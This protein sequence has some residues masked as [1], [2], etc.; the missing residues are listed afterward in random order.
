MEVQRSHDETGLTQRV[1]VVQHLQRPHAG[2][3]RRGEWRA[4]VGDLSGS[5]HQDVV[6]G[7]D[8]VGGVDPHHSGRQVAL[9]SAPALHGHWLVLGPHE[10]PPVPE[11]TLLRIPVRPDLREQEW[12]M[13]LRF[14]K[15]YSFTSDSSG[16]S[17]HLSSPLDPAN[18]K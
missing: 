5:V 13:I 16:P 8:D 1:P 10:S 9:A 3:Q 12:R 4:V 14:N 7:G 11:E 15:S 18:R 2:P 6:S 17:I